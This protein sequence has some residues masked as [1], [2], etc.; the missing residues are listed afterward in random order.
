M[1]ECAG[2]WGI[3]QAFCRSVQCQRAESFHHPVCVERC[4]LNRQTVHLTLVGWLM[5]TSREAFA[6]NLLESIERRRAGDG[7]QPPRRVR[8]LLS[9]HHHHRS[10]HSNPAISNAGCAQ[11]L[12]RS[13]TRIRNGQRHD[14]KRCG[15]VLRWPCAPRP[16]TG[17]VGLSWRPSSHRQKTR[18]AGVNMQLRSTSTQQRSARGIY[19]SR[20]FGSSIEPL[21]LDA[22]QSVFY[23]VVKSPRYSVNPDAQS[24]VYTCLNRAWR[25]I[26]PW[27]G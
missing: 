5:T 16:C 10:S 19:F 8:L 17:C 4:A 3:K 22:M 25:G 20:A 9:Q 24:C 1:A 13:G 27:Q 6:N 11:L 21:T 12:Q 14:Q 18:T 23:K 15:R 2:G 26:G 7:K